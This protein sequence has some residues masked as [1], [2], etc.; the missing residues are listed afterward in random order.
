[1]EEF[2]VV[3]DRL[4]VME[5]IEMAMTAGC[6]LIRTTSCCLD[7]T[8]SRKTKSSKSWNRS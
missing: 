3:A 2:I 8:R 7:Y 6:N 5:R 4:N 1:M